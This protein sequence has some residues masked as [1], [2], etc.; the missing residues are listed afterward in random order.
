MKKI[1]IIAL[2]SVAVIAIASVLYF[3]NYYY[4]YKS[5]SGVKEK[6]PSTSLVEPSNLFVSCY[7]TDDCLKVKGS[8]CQPSKGGE[9][10]CINKNYMQEYLSSI[11]NLAGKDLEVSCPSIDKTT[12]RSCSCLNNICQLVNQ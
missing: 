3:N 4:F 8:A 2:V 7:K 1:F 10:T 11:E 9:E 5:L 6:Y 12:N